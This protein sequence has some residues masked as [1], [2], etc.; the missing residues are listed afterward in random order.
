M[1]IILVSGQE[2]AKYS[3]FGQAIFVAKR[4]VCEYKNSKVEISHENTVIFSRVI[5]T[6]EI[7]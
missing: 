3:D 7:F 4:I 5:A 2:V 6:D 1:F